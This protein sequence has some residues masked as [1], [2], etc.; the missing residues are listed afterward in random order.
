[1]KARM[2][3]VAGAVAVLLL[4]V[5]VRIVQLTFTESPALAEKARDQH[6]GRL[7]VRA[8][9]GLIVDRRGE[10]MA[11]SVECPSVFAHPARIPDPAAVRGPL[12]AALS[13]DP[14]AV[15]AKLASRSTFV[16]LKRTVTPREREAIQKLGLDAV[17]QVT[18]ARRFYPHQRTAAHVLGFTDVD[19]KGIAGVEVRYD[20]ELRGRPRQVDIERDAR[21][22]VMFVD[23]IDDATAFNGATVELTIDMG[24]QTVAER[25]LE[26]QV[27]A[28]GARAGTVIVLDPWT[29]EV[30][31]LANVPTFDPNDHTLGSPLAWRNRAI[32]D[33]YEPGSTFK[34]LLAAAALDYG[35]ARPDE[36]IFCENGAL[37]V[38]GRTIHDHGRHGWLTVNEVIKVSSNIG[39]A[40]IA[41]RLGRERYGEFLGRFDFPRPS[42]IDLPGEAGGLLRPASSWKPIELTTVAFGQGV[43]V[44]PLQLARA[45]A[46][47]A[48]GGLLMK[49]YVG[50]RAVAPDGRILWERGPTVVRRV[51]SP[52]TARAV[53]GM[54]EGVTQDGG[55][56][57]RARVPGLRVAGKTGT[58]QKVDPGTGHYSPD[59]R[60]ASF[61]GFLP[62]E[63]P[64]LVILALLDEPRTASYGGTVAAP[65]FQ[66]IAAAGMSQLGIPGALT[67]GEW[68]EV[69]ADRP[70][71]AVPPSTA[72]GVPSFIGESLLSAVARARELGW[73]V[74]VNGTGYV[75]SQ[76]PPPGAAAAP[77]KA[78]VLGLSPSSDP[79][80]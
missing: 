44:T 41:E 55:T 8:Q 75:I 16:W 25:A 4:T 66:E 49:P 68:R 60:I 50:R 12:A 21:G 34:A 78:L 51:M 62:V 59:A 33:V 29:G 30:L 58:A 13:L 37:T 72:S 35:V 70:A 65:V 74:E 77:G 18:E 15:A 27:R 54:L 61:V 5:V 52:E 46:A 69:R 31:A 28:T 3:T 67:P 79:L 9:R 56:G 64:R 42:G 57:T 11:S 71:P 23:G 36:M 22:R 20:R 6:V 39:A 10:T 24:L 26:R 1:M 2:L 14:S 7:A 76:V 48:N 53:A 80:S 38:G 17:G 40:K 43:A 73:M 19:L 63:A 45:F 47:I 32:S